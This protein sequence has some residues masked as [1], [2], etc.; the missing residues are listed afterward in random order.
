MPEPVFYSWISVAI[1]KQQ[2]L[3]N[4]ESKKRESDWIDFF[5]LNQVFSVSSN[6]LSF[7]LLTKLSSG[8]SDFPPKQMKLGLA[9]GK[10]D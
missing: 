6:L 1:S 9:M 7:F 5:F 10:I 8:A 4:S 2:G 3:G